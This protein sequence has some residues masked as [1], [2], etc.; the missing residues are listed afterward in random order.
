MPVQGLDN[1]FFDMS[2]IQTLAGQGGNSSGTRGKVF[3]LDSS[4]P[5]NSNNS[6][7]GEGNLGLGSV[8][9]QDPNT[10]AA[11]NSTASD[12][13]LQNQFRTQLALVNLQERVQNQSRTVEILTNILKSRHD[14]SMSA[15]R[16]IK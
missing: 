14:A 15:S 6:S 3:G 2:S 1:S 4:D 16:N 9:S 5:G 13:A 7:I 10:A 11:L 12:N 8:P